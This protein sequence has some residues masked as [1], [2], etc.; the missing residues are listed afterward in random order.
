MG[1]IKAIETVYNGYRFRS[2]LE[3]RWAVFFDSLGVTYEYEKEGFEL[4]DGVRYLPDFW[5]PAINTWLEIKGQL[6]TLDGTPQDY[7]KEFLDPSP[8]LLLCE[9][10]R[11]AQ[12]WPIAC[13]VG[14]PGQ[15]RILLFGWDETNDSLG[16]FE[17]DFA[18]WCYSNEQLTL[19][20]NTGRR[21]RIY[22]SA[23][24]ETVIP[25]FIEAPRKQTYSLA[26]IED[27][28][29]VAKSA[30]FEFGR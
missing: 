7:R 19:H 25:W 3:A 24:F 16:C 20:P 12:N 17:S 9:K 30:R 21:E 6:T 14:T 23:D 8:E 5:L 13:S 10:F 2:R 11:D 27:A 1:M 22:L 15:E 29:E 18:W 28:Y 4:D 26:C